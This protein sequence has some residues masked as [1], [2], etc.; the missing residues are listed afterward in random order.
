MLSH[1]GRGRL[2]WYKGTGIIEREHPSNLG[3]IVWHGPVVSVWRCVF[4]FFSFSSILCSPLSLAIK[5]AQ[6][7]HKMVDYPISC[8]SI[9]HTG[10]AGTGRDFVPG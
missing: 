5:T 7:D 8:N 4:K 1:T 10:R 3:N 6:H 2:V 9:T